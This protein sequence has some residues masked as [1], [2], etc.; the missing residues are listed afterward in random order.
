MWRGMTDEHP[1][2]KE[3]HWNAPKIF[4]SRFNYLSHQIFNSQFLGNL[5]PSEIYISLSFL[6]KFEAWE[7]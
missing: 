7:A 2:G 5:E 3:F 6:Y 1:L 4:L